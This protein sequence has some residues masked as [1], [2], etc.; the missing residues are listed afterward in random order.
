MFFQQ[1]R[2][3]SHVTN[4]P[5][6]ALHQLFPIRL[7]SCRGD[8][9]WSSRNP[10]LSPAEFIFLIEVFEELRYTPNLHKI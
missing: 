7:I 3:T 4:D 9:N 2:A 6:D 8:I 10:D 1:D 5:T